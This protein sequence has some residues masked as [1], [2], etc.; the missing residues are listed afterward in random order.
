MD[1]ESRRLWFWWLVFIALIVLTGIL[2]AHFSSL[3]NK[4]ETNQPGFYSINHFVDGDTIAVNM[5]GA[6]ETVR[7]IGVDTPETHKPNTPV[8]CYGPQA[9]DYTKSL[10]NSNKV[11]LQADP[12]DTNRDRYGRLLRY[13]YLPNGTMVETSLIYN[14]YGFAY[15][16]FPFGKSAE[17]KRMSKQPKQE[18]RDYGP[19]A[20]LRS[21]QTVENKLTQLIDYEK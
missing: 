20:K 8:Q 5:N 13:V 19:L 10:I 6:V 15:T 1:K 16:Q 12:L 11:R 18:A 9:A 2:I 14:G 3:Q 4:L 21:N 7:M 17:F